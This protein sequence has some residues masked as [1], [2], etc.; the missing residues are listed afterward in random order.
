MLCNS[1]MLDNF[2]GPQ[3]VLSV[4]YFSSID[5]EFGYKTLPAFSSLPRSLDLEA[6]KSGK[7]DC[8][9]FSP[10]L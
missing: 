1:L 7:P 10:T 8:E 4:K 5:Y 3:I 2:C 9:S 6:S